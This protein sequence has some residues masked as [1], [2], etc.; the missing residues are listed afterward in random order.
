LISYLLGS[1]NDV[2]KFLI[3]RV[4]L[5][6]R[7]MPKHRYTLKIECAAV[8]I[9]EGSTK[10][11]DSYESLYSITAVDTLLLLLLILSRASFSYPRTDLPDFKN[12]VNEN[13]STKIM[14]PKCLPLG[15]SSEMVQRF[16]KRKSRLFRRDFVK[17]LFRQSALFC[18]RLSRSECQAFTFPFTFAITSS[19]IFTGAGA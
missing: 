18:K 10:K 3:Y 13:F 12:G 2:R 15:I 1:L 14:P 5:F 8:K 9:Q 17:N 19:A 6:P 11:R 16:V 4:H 7:L